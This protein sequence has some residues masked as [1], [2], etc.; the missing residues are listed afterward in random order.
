MPQIDDTLSIT[1]KLGSQILPMTV[2]RKDEIIYRD[3]EK[4][5]NQRFAYYSSKYPQLGNEMYLTMMALDVAVQLKGMERDTDP[6]P[7]VGALQGMLGELEAAI[8]EGSSKK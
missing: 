2:A 6:Q 7:M 1:L 8:A 4:L 3:A 5:I